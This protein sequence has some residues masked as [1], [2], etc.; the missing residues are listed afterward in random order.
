MQPCLICKQMFLPSQLT[1]TQECRP[2]RKKVRD[3][4]IAGGFIEP[5]QPKK[6]NPDA[7]QVRCPKCGE[8]SP[9]SHFRAGKKSVTT[10][11]TCRRRMQSKLAMRKLRSSRVEEMVREYEL[12]EIIDNRL[13][14]ETEQ[15]R[16]A[17]KSRYLSLTS[18][19]RQRL[20]KM[21]ANPNPTQ[22]TLTAI[23]LRKRWQQAHVEAYQKQ[24]EI[25]ASGH[26]PMDILE[27]VVF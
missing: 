23:V 26:D 21:L 2:C 22:K 10:C 1:D 11:R 20:K 25:L 17:L 16:A 5:P 12:S 13:Y 24:L 19:S 6:P 8:K 18:A 4:L 27:Y 3:E 7:I 14:A 9:I 15:K